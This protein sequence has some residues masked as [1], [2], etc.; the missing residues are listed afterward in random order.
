MIF[1]DNTNRERSD[2]YMSYMYASLVFFVIAF[3]WCVNDT[4]NKKITEK[5]K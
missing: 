3:V 5:N 1:K 2:Y 4:N